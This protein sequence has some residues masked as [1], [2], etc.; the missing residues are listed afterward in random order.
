[1][2]NVKAVNFQGFQAREKTIRQIIFWTVIVTGI[3][4]LFIPILIKAQPANVCEVFGNCTA[5]IDQYSSGGTN[6]AA[7]LILSI[8]YAAVYI[9]GAIATLFII[10][11]GYSM[12]S[13][14]GDPTKYKK[15]LETVKNA[16]VGV[17]LAIVSF[18]LVSVI[19]NIFSTTDVIGHIN[20]NSAKIVYMVKNS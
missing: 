6:N 8:A 14:S 17:I 3:M 9:I 2:K 7:K 4:A 13:S 12:I 11:G 18:A 20:Q 5:G 19:G 10:I 16:I 1:M 15:G